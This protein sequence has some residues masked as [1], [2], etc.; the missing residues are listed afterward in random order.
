V[1]RHNEEGEKNR[2]ILS[3]I[4]DSVT[5]C[6]AFELALRGHDETENS[7]KPRIFLGLVD[8]VSSVDTAMKEHTESSSVFKDT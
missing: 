6:G 3:T 4:T 5:F 8:L 1:Q 7:E 2:Y